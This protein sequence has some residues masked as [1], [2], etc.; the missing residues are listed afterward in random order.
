VCQTLFDGQLVHLSPMQ[1]IKFGQIGYVTIWKQLKKKWVDKSVKCIMVGYLDDHSGD[2]YW[3]Y[4]PA[5]NTVR[6]T[7]DVHWAA[8]MHTDPTETMQI[9]TG[10]TRTMNTAGALDN[11]QLP[12]VTID[13]SNDNDDDDDDFND[14]AGRK[15]VD[16]EKSQE[17]NKA[18]TATDIP[19]GRTATG[20]NAS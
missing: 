18:M 10:G 3:M 8:W 20:N 2:T 19:A 6:N 5:M 14:K 17:G 13:N 16:D 12:T 7:Q 11:D 9:F 4:D 1:L 15:T